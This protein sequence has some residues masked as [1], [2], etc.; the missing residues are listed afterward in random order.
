MYISL[1]FYKSR[2]VPIAERIMR[3]LKIRQRIVDHYYL[4]KGFSYFE[5]VCTCSLACMVYTLSRDPFVKSIF[6]SLALFAVG[7][8][9]CS[10][11]DAW[12]MPN[13]IS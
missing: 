3:K 12:E 1:G 10:E 11:L 5:D 6:A 4:T 7:L 13:R 9:L 8:K 2:F